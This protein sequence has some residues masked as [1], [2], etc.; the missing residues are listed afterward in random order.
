[1]CQEVDFPVYE[2][3]RSADQIGI[4]SKKWG[5]IVNE[6][7]TDADS[8]G[9]SFPLELDTKHKA[10]FLA[11]CF[12]IVSND[13]DYSSNYILVLCHRTSSISRGTRRDSTTAKVYI[14]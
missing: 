1:M 9:V 12:L 2:Y 7:L 10:L 11:A 5:G 14:Y 13:F 3:G 6:I 4:I 8:F